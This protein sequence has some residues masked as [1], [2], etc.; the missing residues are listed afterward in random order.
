MCLRNPENPQTN[1][2]RRCGA[3]LSPSRQGWRRG[4]WFKQGLPVSIGAVTS[5]RPVTPCGCFGGTLWSPRGAGA[6]IGFTFLTEGLQQGRCRGEA[7]DLDQLCGQGSIHRAGRCQPSP[8]GAL[9]LLLGPSGCSPSLPRAQPATLSLSQAI[10]AGLTGN[11][12]S[13]LPRNPPPAPSS[14]GP[15]GAVPTAPRAPTL[16]GA[17]HR[18]HCHPKQGTR[19]PCCPHSPG[20]HCRQGTAPRA[21][22]TAGAKLRHHGPR[23]HS[24]EKLI[25]KA[26]GG[27]PDSL[28]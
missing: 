5:G 27:K 17:P 4:C 3:E 12:H 22:A 16:P 8:A 7:Q 1:P 13:Q 24:L 6:T 9:G 10:Q 25:E 26:S 21:H 15:V 14:T 20:C 2:I 18:W 23:K 19:S 11:F 28:H